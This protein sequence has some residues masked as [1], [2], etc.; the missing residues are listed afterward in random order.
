VT[1]T[2]TATEIASRRERL[3]GL[4]RGASV[5]ALAITRPELIFYLAGAEP[6][7][8]DPAA[9]LLKGDEAILVWPEAVPHGLASG[10]ETITYDPYAGARQ[11]TD[12]FVQQAASAAALLGLGRCHVGRDVD[13]VP[14]WLPCDGVELGDLL[15]D[16][17]RSKSD[18][19]VG[20]IAA[21]LAANDRAFAVV[22]Q[23]L[24]SGCSDL[25]VLDWCCSA[26]SQAS[27]GPVAYE[28]NIGLG[29]RGDYFDAQ[30]GG[31]I[32]RD[33]DS[34]FVDL[35]CRIDH[36]VGDSTRC[37]AVGS[38]PAWL[39]DAHAVL[40]Q[41]LHAMEQHLR[42]G[43]VAGELDRRCREFV[44]AKARRALFPHHVGHGIGLRAHEPPYLVPGSRDCL[45]PG[46]VVAIEPGL[47]FAG[48]G[49]A[50]L[51]E[52]YVITEG[53]ARRLTRHPWALME[54]GEDRS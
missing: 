44:D 37:F 10:I 15:S 14:S 5:D 48:R 53:A 23:R 52:V 16:L 13:A 27:T 51:E 24:A 17:T 20:V 47:Y 19:E 50:R 54:N 32:A 40:E 43:A 30:P 1:S 12:G 9:L 4:L 39:R 7:P 2:P 34:L 21:N 11:A 46:D 33:G 29:P 38:A 28:G 26:L 8:G 6:Y 3:G 18:A 22:A 36:Y 35:Y 41:A 42:P 45:R 31:A 25:D 49:G